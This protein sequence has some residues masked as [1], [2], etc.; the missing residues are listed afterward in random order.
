MHSPWVII[1]EN[2]SSEIYMPI[3][4]SMAPQDTN[5]WTKYKF[6]TKDIKLLSSIKIFYS[7]N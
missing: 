3:G 2:L 1:N 6:P 7:F 5:E 4:F